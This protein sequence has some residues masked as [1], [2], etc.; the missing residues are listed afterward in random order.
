MSE[1][2]RNDTKLPP[3]Q[4]AIR[5]KC[6]HPTGRFEEFAKE[7]V[8]QSIPDRFEKI[9]KLYPDRVAI[10]EREQAVTYTELNERANRI[11]HAI[12]DSC[13]DCNQ[14]VAI[15]MEH[16]ASVLVAILAVLKAGKIYVPLDPSYPVERLQYM[17]LDAQAELIVAHCGTLSLA[18][19]IGGEDFAVIDVD[20][21][22]VGS[23]HC[24]V[25]VKITPGAFASILYTS[26]STGQPKGVVDNHRNLLH[27]T[28][29]FTRGLHI[30]SEDRLSLTYSC[31]SSAS[32]R[33]IFP[34]LLNGACLFPLDLKR[35]GI[36]GLVDLLIIESISVFS[37][38]RIR[39]FVRSFTQHQS[40]PSLRLVSLG[41][42]IVYRR[43]VELYKKIFPRDCV[44]GISMS[45]TETGNITQFFIDS[46][47][48]FSGEIAPIGYPAEDVEIILLDDGG[49]P[50]RQGEIGE[51]AVKSE[52]LACG[53]WRRPELTN[54]KFQGDP[55]G[56][57]RRIYRTGDQGHME[58]D[59]CLFH[60]GR[61]DD[62]I[63]VRGYRVEAA[64]IEAALLNLGYFT[65]AF[66]MLR[67]RG[68]DEKSLVAYLVPEKWPAPTSSTLRKALSV[69]LPNH[70]IPAVFVMLDTIPLTPTRKV[71]RNALPDPGNGR[72][73]INTPFVAPS[74]SAER[75]LAKIWCKV[76]SLDQV[77]IHDNFFDLGGHSL[78]AIRVVS[79]V[80]Q[81]FR[82]D[83][84]PNA[85]FDSPTVADMA[86]VIEANRAKLA[87]QEDIERILS[88]VEAMTE[89]KAQ[90][91]LTEVIK[92]KSKASGRE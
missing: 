8:E 3:E 43:D 51:I 11:A 63:K 85:L 37:S 62:Q 25:S 66:V 68:S 90:R 23:R 7:E 22:S 17:L 40:Y 26:G 55:D 20:D 78:A 21:I 5:A 76:L 69:T 13:G 89:E 14:P 64:E 33:R 27:G 67:D 47:S 75:D 79:R 81:T 54:E 36:R 24:D 44:I 34:A 70:T 2:L 88:E 41:G 73:E 86:V 12:L 1:F 58:S 87:S 16:G 15:L 31:S 84:P 74:T 59:G 82:I 29:R 28:L 49:N 4:E 80:I 18:R 45:C 19:E 71:D 77:G 9:V 92:A 65:K 83:L 42:E 53:Y 46:D 72:P 6:F 35:E 91:L 60:L 48:Q 32:V 52:Y 57:Q 56:G 10:K 50:V 38:G 30:C 61:K 39:D